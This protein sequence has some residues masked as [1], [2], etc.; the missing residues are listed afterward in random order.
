MEDAA[1]ITKLHNQLVDMDGFLSSNILSTI[2]NRL[3][4]CAS[5]HSQSMEFGKDLKSLECMVKD[6]EA[7]LGSV[8]DSVNAMESG[9]I[10]N[11]KVIQKNVERLDKS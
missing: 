3:S 4:T 10:E 7:Q 1:K 11:I 6:V 8:E 9:L 5:L 2:V